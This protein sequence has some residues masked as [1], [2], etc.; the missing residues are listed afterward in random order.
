MSTGQVVEATAVANDAQRLA[1]DATAW[2]LELRMQPVT[3]E[4]Q[5]ERGLPPELVLAD[6][7]AFLD[8]MR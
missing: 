6:L 1:T 4:S 3:T 7:N 2:E 8:K 5:P